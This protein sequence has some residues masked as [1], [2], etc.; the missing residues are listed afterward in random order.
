M[1]T[2]KEKQEYLKDYYRIKLSIKCIEDDLKELYEISNSIKNMEYDKVKNIVTQIIDLENKKIL[3][4]D[5]LLKKRKEIEEK[6]KSV[7]DENC[8]LL[9]KY[10]YIMNLTWEEVAEKMY[11][12][13]QYVFILHKKALGM[14]SIDE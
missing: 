3:E 8:R 2:I 6:I 1:K 11:F 4:T 7:Q 13:Y 5:K 14:I 10:R 12:C 9:L